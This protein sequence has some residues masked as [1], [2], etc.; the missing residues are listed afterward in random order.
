MSSVFLELLED[1]IKKKGALS[2]GYGSGSGMGLYWTASL[3]REW[4]Y[5]SGSTLEGSLKVLVSEH[6]R[7]E[8]EET[9]KRI[10]E[11]DASAGL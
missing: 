11:I 5:C 3:G 10:N 6:L 4:P 8:K 9:Q 2:V 1:L 7:L